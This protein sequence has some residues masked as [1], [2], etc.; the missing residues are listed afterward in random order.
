VETPLPW[1]RLLWTGHP[2]PSWH[3]LA[4]ARP[5]YFLTDVRLVATSRRRTDEILLHDIGEVQRIES[6]LDRIAGTSTLVVHARDRRRPAVALRR[7]RRGTQFAALLELLAA[8]SHAVPDTDAV[9][10]ALSWEPRIDA[11]I[12][13]AAFTSLGATL[14]VLFTV[15]ISVHGTSSLVTFAADDAI[16][17]GGMKRSPEEITRFMEDTVMPWA[18]VVLGPVKGGR[19]RVTCATCHGA[20]SES[21]KWQMPAVSALP[22]PHV[23]EGGWEIYST[24]MDAQTRNAIYGYIA[25][26]DNQATAAYMREVVMPGMA[27]LLHRPAY[28][29]TKPYS[30]NRA[31]AAFGCYH[32]HQVR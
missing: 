17:P 3:D 12:Y 30:Y 20:R 24:S 27:R 7:L 8:D 18:R 4:A 2:L 13:R 1:E 16:Y 25:E 6:R 21:R 11:S 32:C 10:A 26:A 5:T 22:M 14:A 29:F 28:D 15:A 23:S 9:R 19:E 31:R